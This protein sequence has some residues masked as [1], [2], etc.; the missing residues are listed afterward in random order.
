M[1]FA[2][3]TPE[4]L[5]S[6]TVNVQVTDPGSLSPDVNKDH[7]GPDVGPDYPREMSSRLSPSEMNLFYCTIFQTA[8]KTMGPKGRQS[9]DDALF[10]GISTCGHRF[11]EL[12]PL[13]CKGNLA[14]F[15]QAEQRG[16]S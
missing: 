2:F 9:S 7:P 5:F 12:P 6:S 15:K 14:L 3:F 10:V 4:L 1:L 13:L 8:T 11:R 16:G